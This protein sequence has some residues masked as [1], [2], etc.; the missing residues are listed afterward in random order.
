MKEEDRDNYLG[1]L[2]YEGLLI[3]HMMEDLKI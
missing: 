2:W 1:I 3:G